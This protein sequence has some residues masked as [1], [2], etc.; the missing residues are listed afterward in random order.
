LFS[1]SWF[2][3]RSA[4]RHPYRLA[5]S[6]GVLVLALALASAAPAARAQTAPAGA[7]AVESRN[8]LPAEFARFA[9]KN[10]LDMLN[11]VPGFAIRSAVVER[12]LGEATGNVLLNGERISNKSD[13]IFAQLQRVPAGNVV[14]IEI[15][16]GATMGIPGL[17]GQV[18]NVVIKAA[19]ISG[20]YAYR[21]EFRQYHTD[22]IYDRFDVSVSGERG[23][24][25][26]TLGLEN[27]VSHSGAGGD[28]IILNGSGALTERR[29]DVWTSNTRQPRVSG[30]FVFRGPNDSLGNLNLSLRGVTSEYVE[31]G[32]RRG[33]NA[34][35]RERDVFDTREGWDY[36]VGG[37]YRFEVGAGQLKL[38]GLDRYVK[39]D[40]QTDVLVDYADG[41]PRTGNRSTRESEERERILRG[42]YQRKLGVADLE[43]SAEA[44][45]NSLDS[46]ARLFTLGPGGGYTE[47]PFP[48]ATAQV[49]ESRYEAIASYGR[50]LSPTLSFRLAAGGEFSELAQIGGGGQTRSFWRPKGQLT[51][52]WQYDPDTRLN[53]RIQR[54]VGQLNFFDF[55]ASVSLSDDRETSA[56]PDLVPPQSWEFEVETARKHGA[57]GNSTARLYTHLVEDIID[58]IPIGDDGEAVGNLDRAQ[59]YG[60]EIRNTTNLDPMG[61]RGVRIDSRLWLQLTRVEDP[62]TKEIRDIGS[63]LQQFASLNLRHD[64]PETPWAYG[65]GLSH[66]RN[67]PSYRVTEVSRSWEIPVFGSAFVEHKD[68]WGLTVRASVAN[69]FYGESYQYRRVFNGRRTDPVS[70]IEMRDRDIGPIFNLDIRGKF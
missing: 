63:S 18:A 55:L 34:V 21:P 31:D 30:R 26:F 5:A 62:L 51:A 56:N 3:R 43:L 10:A 6:L 25:E 42:E 47:T 66:Q 61:W 23:P 65:A 1:W 52:V 64:I 2:L 17:S 49:E 41:R 9:P 12:G 70:F 58:F 46:A 22:P 50:A 32:L 33:P 48:N 53:F 44:A 39:S 38:I 8:Y 60:I 16:D 45:F 36:E 40:V 27:Q 29:D 57:W 69:I 59:R 24:L 67:A 4:T 7:Q 68:V 54:R 20:R 14:R 37:D 28:T 15:R 35:D 19:R 11:Q 13:D